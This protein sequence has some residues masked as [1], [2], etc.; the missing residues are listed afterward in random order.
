[1]G[2]ADSSDTRALG[3]VNLRSWE[4]EPTVIPN[5]AQDNEISL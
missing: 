2:Y 4:P 5:K 1:V 3:G